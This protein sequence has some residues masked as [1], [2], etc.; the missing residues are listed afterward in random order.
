MEWIALNDKKQIDDI[1]TLS[2][3]KYIVLF[4]HS[5]R[6]IISKMALRNFEH[7]FVPDDRVTGYFLD[8]LNFRELSDGIADQFKVMHQSPQI[9]L[10]KDRKAIYAESHEGIDADMM[11]KHLL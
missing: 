3:T 1:L 9:I 10:V 11:R 5:T 4:K 6:C 7:D 2:E 8:I